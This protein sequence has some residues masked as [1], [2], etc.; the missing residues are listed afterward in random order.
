M[1]PLSRTTAL[2][3][4]S[5][6]RRGDISVLGL[7]SSQRL[8]LTCC[9]G[10]SFPASDTPPRISLTWV[11]ELGDHKRKCHQDFFSTIA[12]VIR[13]KLF[14]LTGYHLN[15]ICFSLKW[16]AFDSFFSHTVELNV[17][18]CGG[19]TVLHSLL[20]KQDHHFSVNREPI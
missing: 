13:S 5:L 18:L 7:S 4:V 2:V 8:S 16:A 20:L 6:Q 11:K 17:P 10:T 15:I 9:R 19:G 14:V 12:E 1:F 3:Y